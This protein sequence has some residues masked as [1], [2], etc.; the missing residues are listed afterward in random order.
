MQPD[1]LHR[2]ME[3]HQQER[4]GQDAPDEQA[5]QR[6]D[7]ARRREFRIHIHGFQV[8]RGEEAFLSRKADG[9]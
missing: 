5:K 8:T 9:K 2:D 3:E 1:R 6:L 7:Q 4:G